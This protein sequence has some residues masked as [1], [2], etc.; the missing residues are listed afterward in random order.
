MCEI[1]WGKPY[2]K[3]VT[4]LEGIT[5]EEWHYSWVKNLHFKNGILVKIEY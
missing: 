4:I 1:S 2:D 3:S 5:I